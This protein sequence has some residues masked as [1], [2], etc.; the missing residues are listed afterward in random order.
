MKEY[1]RLLGYLKKYKYRFVLGL[2]FSLLASVFNA[3]SL[4]SL[5]PIFQTMMNQGEA[6]KFKLTLNEKEVRLIQKAGQ[7]ELLKKLNQKLGKA[8]EN[9]KS[10][11]PK[12]N[13]SPQSISFIPESLLILSAKLKILVN[14]ISSRYTP[15]E[16]LFIVCMTILPLYLLKL[17]SITGTVYFI[18]STGLRAVRDIRQELFQKLI[19]LP[20]SHFIREKSG[21]LMS[22][23]INDATVISHSLSD[24]LRKS[25][26]NFFIIVTHFIMLAI[27]D[28]KLVLVCMVGVPLTLWPVS[29][30]SRK[31]RR[32]SS[33]EQASM[34]D[35]NGELQEMIGGIRVI[36]AFGMEDYQA[37]RFEKI[38]DFMYHQTFRFHL[39]HTIGPSLVEFVTS[40]I[41]VGLLLYGASRIISSDMTPGSF[42]TFFFTLIV[43]LSPVKQMATWVNQSN[44]AAAA[45]ERI[46]EIIDYESESEAVLESTD[47]QIRHLPNKLNKKISFENVFF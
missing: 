18:A 38:N 1:K 25:I 28:Y 34:G 2:L 21:V 37:K 14:E 19:E 23:I 42:F 16:F 47:F 26:V 36:R 20:L 24:E 10:L 29:H 8:K 30:F 43:V 32:I 31:I 9:S 22:R 41:V 39:N 27:I 6:V 4:S 15:L 12:S 46:F 40:F 33:G 3:I 5:M 11:T 13:T 44:R 17:L 7:G 45:G 35:L